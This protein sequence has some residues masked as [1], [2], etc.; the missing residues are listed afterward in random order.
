MI[1]PGIGLIAIGFLPC[2]NPE[3]GLVFISI[4]QAMAEFGF[5][6]GYMFSIFE[7]APKYA[8]VL[9][10]I[11]NTFG[12]IP[13]F[14]VPAF[15]AYMTPNGSRAEWTFVF[16]LAGG[17][18]IFGALVYLLFG[19]SELQPW[20]APDTGKKVQAPKISQEMIDLQRKLI[21]T[22]DLANGGGGGGVTYQ[23]IRHE[24]D[25]NKY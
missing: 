21:E 1:S 5:M 16:S 9:T 22:N 25:N 13:G 10:G 14:L 23:Q 17:V 6:G 4:C 18:C 12:V 7:L 2:S 19:S 24:D 11:T 8:G 15:V 3:W 20:A